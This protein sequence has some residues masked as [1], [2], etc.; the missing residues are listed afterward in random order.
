MNSN[1][2]MH[3]PVVD[4]YINSAIQSEHPIVHFIKI[5]LYEHKGCKINKL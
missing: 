5:R 1:T 2:S 3:G 4:Y